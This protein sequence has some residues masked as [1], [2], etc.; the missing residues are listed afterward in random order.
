[1]SVSDSD[2]QFNTNYLNE[3]L[4]HAA[5]KNK[6][7][8]Y[9]PSADKDLYHYTDLAG[10]LGVVESHDLWSTHSKYLNDMSEMK[11]GYDTA[12][13]VI[14]QESEKKK[15]EDWAN[16]CKLIQDHVD[17]YT[18]V[19][20]YVC[21]FCASDNLLS[22][23]RNYGGNGTG[24]RIAFNSQRCHDIAT[25]CS[26]DY[27]I[28]KLWRVSYDSAEESEIF[29]D[30]ID[31]AFKFPL[32][33]EERAFQAVKLIEF[34]V[35]TIKNKDFREED[36][37]RLIFIPPPNCPVKP[38]FRV[39][40]GMVIPYYSLRELSGKLDDELYR[41]PITGVRVG[42]SMNRELNAES[43]QMMLEHAGYS[44]IKV[45]QSSTPYRG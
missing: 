45:D 43:I 30:A 19:G 32:S 37:Y 18:S 44:G 34:F 2:N 11:H 24:V 10:I 8:N 5:K 17:N 23:W 14:K 13:K 28:M 25:A 33:L 27:G 12:L 7:L 42:P 6:A 21:C 22:Q 4:A 29:E 3:F 20:V 16:Y 41:L 15:S 31:F 9:T 1:M 26:T 35:P 39:G 36:E 40:R 38:R